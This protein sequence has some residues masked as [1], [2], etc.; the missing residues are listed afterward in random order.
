MIDPQPA[1]HAE[2]SRHLATMVP[3]E[4]RRFPRPLF[5]E[6]SNKYASR[7]EPHLAKACLRSNDPGSWAPTRAA[8]RRA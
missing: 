8:A 4:G 6:A 3:A 5:D 2:K 1:E 7:L